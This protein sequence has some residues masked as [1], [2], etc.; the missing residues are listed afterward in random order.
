M[1]GIDAIRTPRR[2]RAPA[3]D[4]RP[5][6]GRAGTTGSAPPA[7]TAQRSTSATVFS[8][9]TDALQAAVVGIGAA[10]AREHVVVPYL[11]D[12]R[13]V[14]LPGP[15]LPARWGYYVVYPSHRRLRPAAQAFVDWLLSA[16]ID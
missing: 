8:D 7:C 10:L 4:H 3:A 11:R 14:R 15:A 6:R 12:G 5:S 16:Q 1:P 9:T 13:L 2:H